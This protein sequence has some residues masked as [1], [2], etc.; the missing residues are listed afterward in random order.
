MTP[1]A[2]APPQSFA[3]KASVVVLGV[4][5]GFSLSR[6]GFTDYGE[7]ARMFTFAD[8]RMFLV[9]AGGVVVTGLGLRAL[10]ADLPR[11]PVEPRVIVGGVLFG[12]GWAIAGACPGV[13]FAQI[14]EG[15]LWALLSVAG[16]FAGTALVTRLR[17]SA[18]EAPHC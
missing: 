13:A 9:F 18:L 1:Q 4:V 12:L 7:L 14:G 5:L 16:M 10:K 3:R 8:L 2:V 6:I 11:R 17:G 15:K